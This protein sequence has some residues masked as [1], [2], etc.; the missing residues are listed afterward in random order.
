MRLLD[1]PVLTATTQPVNPY[2]SF[3]QIMSSNDVSQ[4]SPHADL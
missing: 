3:S 1:R 2:P 4:V